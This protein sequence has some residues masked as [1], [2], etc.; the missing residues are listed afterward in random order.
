[1]TTKWISFSTPRVSLRF[2]T[3]VYV[4]IHGK[5]QVTSLVASPDLVTGR[6]R[7]PV[8]SPLHHH[9]PVHMPMQRAQSG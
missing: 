2:R 6:T 1:M 8:R 5:T 4:G 9:T 3:P 7:A